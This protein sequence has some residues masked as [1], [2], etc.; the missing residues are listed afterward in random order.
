MRH[1]GPQTVTARSRRRRAGLARSGMRETRRRADHGFSL[2]EIL[3]V[4]A[5]VGVLV[6]AVSIGIATAGG[7]RQLAREAERLQALVGHACARAELSGREIGIRVDAEG[8]AFTT[9]GLDGWMADEQQGE[10]RPRRWVRGLAVE[11]RR[12]GHALRIAEAG[13]GGG[14]GGPQIVCFSSGELSPF[15][16]RL[17]LGDVGARY[18]LR[19]HV[20]GRVELQR[21]PLP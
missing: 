13:S 1:A 5:I 2:I 7:E 18:E 16:V 12:D 14:E 15:L 19:G 21:M 4:L 11:M 8:Y 6:L 20:D 10:L 17:A 3:V 9:L